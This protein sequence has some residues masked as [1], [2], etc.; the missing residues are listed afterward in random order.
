V[1]NQSSISIDGHQI[2]YWT[3]GDKKKQPLIFV[4]GFTGS[5]EGFQYIVPRLQNDFY[6]IVPDLPGFGDSELG[7]DKWGIDEIAR[8]MNI[9]TEELGLKTKPHVI[10]HSMGGLVAASMLAQNPELYQ[11]KAVFISPAV[12]KVQ[13]I[14]KVGAAIPTIQYG[15]G[16]RVPILGPK[17]VKNKTYSKI[18]TKAI[19]TTKDKQLKKTI[20]Q[21][22]I[23][24]LDY[25]SSIAF[26]HQ[27]HKE[28]IQ[29]GAIDYA[30]KLKAFDVLIITGTNDNV[31]PLAGQKRLQKELDAKLHTIDGVGHL[32]HYEK[33]TEVAVALRAFLIS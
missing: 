10:A 1:K 9:F 20:N 26:Y 17:L 33:P 27:M 18:A 13:G 30:H 16:K 22:H 19:M 32:L 25:I 8:R 4:H 11:K 31:T 3:Y 15:F 23:R 29:T 12:E 6:L 24:N 5:N 21:H 2:Q 7:D 28:I 14:R